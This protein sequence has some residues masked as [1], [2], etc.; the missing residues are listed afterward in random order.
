MNGRT[1]KALGIA[2]KACPPPTCGC[3]GSCC[4]PAKQTAAPVP[5]D[6]RPGYPMTEQG[7]LALRVLRD[8]CD[9]LGIVEPLPALKWFWPNARCV[10]QALLDRNEIW[11]DCHS[12]N[13]EQ[14]IEV[15]GEELA[16]I[17]QAR[18]KLL[19]GT[20]PEPGAKATAR[21]ILRRWHE[22]HPRA[23]TARG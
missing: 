14:L 1:L 3:G 21:Y 16:H 11:I 20:D 19:C 17:G 4:S 10:G 22:R 18:G 9:F 7:G 2:F 8:A 23:S 12:L 5:T 15:I 6:L 13:D